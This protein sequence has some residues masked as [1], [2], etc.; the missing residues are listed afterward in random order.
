MNTDRKPWLTSAIELLEIQQAHLK[1]DGDEE[2]YLN[3]L[4][5]VSDPSLEE[6]EIPFPPFTGE[7]FIANHETIDSHPYA[8]AFGQFLGN[9]IDPNTANLLAFGINCVDLIS[10]D[11]DDPNRQT[12]SR[13]FGFFEDIDYWRDSEDCD[14]V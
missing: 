12:A 13:I 10:D 4:H 5:S 7:E 3:T 11:I 14:L 9:G 1:N 8:V 6:E 2:D